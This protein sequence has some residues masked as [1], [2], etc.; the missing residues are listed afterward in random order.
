MLRIGRN[1]RLSVLSVIGN[2]V[3]LSNLTIFFGEGVECLQ[4]LNT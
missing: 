1:K 3:Y 4:S 2:T